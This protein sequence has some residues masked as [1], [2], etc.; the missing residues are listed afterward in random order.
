MID[1]GRVWDRRFAEQRWPSDPDRFLVELASALPAGR[2][3]DLG[4][5]PGR[6]SLWLAAKGWA[7]T[8][9][10][11]SSVALAQALERGAELGVDVD[12]V[13]A[14]VTGWHP[15]E[16][17]YDLALVAYLHPGADGLATV[18]ANAAAALVPGGHLFVIGHDLANLGRHGPPDPARLLT[19]ERLAAAM[20]P[21]IAVE[22][23][24]RRIRPATD[25]GD[26]APGGP[27]EAAVL[28]WG[29]RRR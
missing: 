24:E 27:A 14:D 12:V 21:Q 8:A 1:V 6:N 11:A 9:V 17:R 15:G 2:V 5:G 13:H 19:P 18:L 28:G 16:Q 4:S 7:V 25:P 29:S 10:D 20:P 26:M 3:L 22:V 23:L